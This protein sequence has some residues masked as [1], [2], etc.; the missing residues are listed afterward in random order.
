VLI[1]S[2]RR[3]DAWGAFGRWVLALVL[4]LCSGPNLFGQLPVVEPAEVGLDAARLARIDELVAEGIADKRMPGCVVCIGRK[5]KIAWL[6]AYGNKQLV[7]SEVPMTTDTVFDM[8][9]ITK[10]VA[11]AT[12]VMLLVE[13]GQLRLSDKVADRI[14]EFAA[15]GKEGI[16]IFDLLTHQSGLLPDNKLSDYDDGPDQALARIYALDLQ[17]PTGTKFI[18]S[19]VNYILLAELVRRASG[20]N[21]HEFSQ[22]HLFGPLGM[23]ETG[24]LP[25]EALRARA[26]PTE[27]REGRWMQGEVH[28]P[29]A[30]KLGGIAGHAGL[31]STATDLAMYAQM[32]ID[33]GRAGERNILAPQTVATMTRAYSVPGGAKRGLGW[34]KRS[35]YSSNRGELLTDAAFGHGGFT[36]TVLWI[37]PELELFV[38]FLSNRVH[39]DGKGLVNP[40]AGRIGTVAAGA[41]LSP[42]QPRPPAGN[43]LTGIDVLVRDNFRSVAGRKVG[44]ITNHTGRSADGQTTVELLHAAPGVTLAAL[45]SPEHG[46]EG[47]LDVAKIGDAQ[48]GT[49][50]LKIYSLYGETRRPTAEMLAGIDTIVFDIQDIGARF[51]TYTSTMGEAMLAAAEQKKRFVVLDRPNPIGGTAVAGP[52]LDE[53][54]ESFV[55][56]HT[57]PVRHGMTIGELAQLIRRERKLDLEL[58]IVRC[59]GWQRGDLWDATGL[60]WV[61]PSPN[62]RNLTQALVYPG[63]G[64]LETTNLSVGRGTDTP[65]EIF[66]APWIDPR[67]LAARLREANLPGVAF[68]PIEFTPTSS[69]FASETCRGVNVIVTDREQFEPLATGL[70]I[71]ATLR[72]LYPEKWEAQGYARLLGNEAVQEALLAGKSGPELVGISREGVSQFMR[73][74][75]GVLLYE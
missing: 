38:I 67:A 22:E 59:E 8:A 28:D 56:F 43:V 69:K 36:G 66:G 48:D 64:L 5:R 39:P 52:M 2:R 15:N 10:P 24:Y 32:M 73:R 70:T 37:D 7:P 45:F 34:D 33:R 21:V 72:S 65:F 74:R 57:L 20:Q 58:E 9:S 53:G 25:E 51:Y 12:S 14:H 29:R 27:E 55:G 41:I 30:Y 60:V 54:K 16:T 44:L 47:K 17:A 63:I 49:T 23:R 35:G 4:G 75:A 3:T 31:F 62:M 71:A 26:A 46:F 19:D 40:L 13:R 42:S 1:C 6:K 68:V 11:T 61:N 50:G 18:Y